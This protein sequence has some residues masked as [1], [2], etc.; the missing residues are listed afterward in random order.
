MRA[1]EYRPVGIGHNGGPAWLPSS[2]VPSDA[3]AVIRRPDRSA[4]TSGLMRTREW[5]LSFERRT[6]PFIDR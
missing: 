5:V 4:M 2:C 3:T 1:N 6:P